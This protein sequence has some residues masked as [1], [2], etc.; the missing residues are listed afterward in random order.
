MKAY[1]SKPI[2]KLK[3]KKEKKKAKWIMCE[4]IKQFGLEYGPQNL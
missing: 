4:I 3:K 2:K 1:K